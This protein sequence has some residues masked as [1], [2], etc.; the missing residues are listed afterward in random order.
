MEQGLVPQEMAW[1]KYLS[2][3][4][5]DSFFP[6]SKGLKGWDTASFLRQ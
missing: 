5:M 1:A 6:S 4:G 2:A 3:H